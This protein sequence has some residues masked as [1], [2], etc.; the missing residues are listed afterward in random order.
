M[1]IVKDKEG[2][3][4][5]WTKELDKMPKAFQEKYKTWSVKKRNAWLNRKPKK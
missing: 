1:G 4:V 3:P 2:H 5:L